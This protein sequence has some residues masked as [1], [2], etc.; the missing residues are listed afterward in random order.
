MTA[1][2]TSGQPRWPDFLDPVESM[3]RAELDAHQAAALGAM[4]HYAFERSPL[5]RQAWAA[6]GITPRDIRSTA[7]FVALAPFIDK[8]SVRAFRDAHDDPAGGMGHYGPGEIVSVGTT[9][10]TT[11]DPTP[12]P[13]GRRSPSEESF[14]R[15]LWHL[16]LRPGGYHAHIMFTFRGGHRRRSLQE[17]GI[18]EI[19]FSFDPREMPRLCEA[20]RRYRPTTM[21][22]MPN[23]LLM[24]LEAHFERSGEDP[25]D[26]FKSYK[27]AIFGG[28]PLSAR[29]NQVAQSWGLEIYENTSLGDVCGAT[30]CTARAGMH[31]Y[32][33]LAFI[34]CIEPGGTAPVRD[35]E[36]GELVVTT[37]VDRFTPLV[38]YRS[39]DLVTLDRSPCACGRSHVRFKVLGRAS[40]Q[41]VIDGR[42]VLPREV[43]GLV[44]SHDESRNGLFQI[45]RPARAMDVLRL[46]IGYDPARCAVAPAM[47]RDR[48]RGHLGEAI[49]VA[50]E[51]ELVVEGELLKLG[52]P[53]KIPRVTTQ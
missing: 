2:A 16:G 29:L 11:G 41:I 50:V 27:G 12:L 40:D 15:D 6:A 9:S 17:L 22:I 20:S 28:E 1:S 46:R 51:V 23:P 53:H 32:E 7:D 43:M 47:L 37:L 31:A 5:I 42:S 19:V 24:A 21:S 4:G 39:G 26:T 8:D 13:N 33:D 3:S 34:E 25:V 49:G 44:E 14:A 38:R 52:P 18:A 10:G 36:I 30:E 35:G 48:L 45:I